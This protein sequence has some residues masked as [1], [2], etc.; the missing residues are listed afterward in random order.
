MAYSF[1]VALRFSIKEIFEEAF[2]SHM[3]VLGYN[4]LSLSGGEQE[5]RGFRRD[6]YLISLS[7]TSEEHGLYRVIVHSETV[8]LD[9]L[10]LAAMQ[11]AATSLLEP[12]CQ[13]LTGLPSQE[14]RETL[15]RNLGEL[16]TNI[17]RGQS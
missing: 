3:D 4:R 16:L 9:D 13:A 2:S 10:V 17:R 12:L 6:D 7:V 14:L 5:V 11:E 15:L 8:P 1:E